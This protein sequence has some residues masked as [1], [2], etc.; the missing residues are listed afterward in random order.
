[1]KAKRLPD[2]RAMLNLGCGY[3]MN[4]TWTNIDFSAYARLIHHPLLIRFLR[5]VGFLSQQRSVRLGMIDP[6]IVLWDLRRGIPF[7][8]ET[9][10]VV[11]SSHFLE[12]LEQNA[13]KRLLEECHRVL[14]PGGI[15]RIV[16]PDLEIIV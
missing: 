13:A 12:H 4:W 5:G 7:G 16:V 11:Y 15:V 6:Q 2:G 14:H 10:S 9:F 1:M 3:K 8:S